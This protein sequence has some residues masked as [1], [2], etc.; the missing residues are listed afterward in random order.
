MTIDA[1]SISFRLLSERDKGE[2]EKLLIDAADDR[3]M[4]TYYNQGIERALNRNLE[5]VDWAQATI[6]GCFTNRLIAVLGFFP[7]GYDNTINEFSMVGLRFDRSA[8]ILDDLFHIGVFFIA[9]KN[10]RVLSVSRHFRL[11]EGYRI[12]AKLPE[13]D[14]DDDQ[15]Y[16]DV[17]AYME[18]FA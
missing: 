5:K 12:V 17:A 4:S 8:Q 2:I 6:I 1:K 18:T 15:I 14:R 11:T 7:S 16:F 3:S 10:C 9:S 13:I